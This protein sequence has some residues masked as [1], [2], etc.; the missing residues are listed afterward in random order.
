MGLKPH[1]EP[2]H[3]GSKGSQISELETSLVY[4]VRP[5][6]KNTTNKNSLDPEDSWAIH[7]LW[8]SSSSTK[9]WV[10]QAQRFLKNVIYMYICLYVGMYLCAE[11]RRG[12]LSW[13][14]RSIEPFNVG[15]GNQLR[16]SARA[17][18]PLSSWTISPACKDLL[19]IMFIFMGGLCI[20]VKMPEGASLWECVGSPG[21]AVTAWCKVPEANLGLLQE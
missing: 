8:R 14:Y 19:L 11:T 7:G 17:A 4:L 1:P 5:Y 16:S 18:C 20:A 9:M 13:S 3:L 10:L 15:D 12:C 6:L 21:A 2:Q